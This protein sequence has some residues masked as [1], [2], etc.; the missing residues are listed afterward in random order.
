LKP[1]TGVDGG[2]MFGRKISDETKRKIGS[3]NRGR[4]MTDEYCKMR[5]EKQKG[6]TP[7][8]KGKKGLQVSKNK[9]KKLPSLTQEHRAKISNALKGC[10]KPP[11]SEEHS[12][13]IS[14]AK[15]GKFG[16]TH[17]SSAKD[18]ISKAH[19][20]RRRMHN[21]QLGISIKMVPADKIKEFLSNGWKFNRILK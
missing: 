21:D 13:N 3:A 18:K 14:K 7:W 10:P 1:E 5:S 16:H 6:K 8:N 12:K 11:R 15:I 2:G 9:G 4:K 17:D 19:A 20:G